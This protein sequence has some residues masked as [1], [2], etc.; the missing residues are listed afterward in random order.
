MTQARLAS[1]KFSRRYRRRSDRF[2]RSHQKLDQYQKSRRKLR[3]R[4]DLFRRLRRK[5]SRR[6]HRKLRVKFGRRS[7]RKSR[8]RYSRR[9]HPI[10]IGRDQFRKLRPIR[11]RSHIRKF[12]PRKHRGRFLKFPQNE[13]GRFLK[14][15]RKERDRYPKSR[16]TGPDRYPKSHRILQRRRV[17]VR[18]KNEGRSQPAGRS[19]LRSSA[20]LSSRDDNRITQTGCTHQHADP[21]GTLSFVSTRFTQTDARTRRHSRSDLL[22]VHVFRHARRLAYQRNALRRLSLHVGRMDMDQ[23]RVWRL[24]ERRRVLPDLSQQPRSDLL[25]SRLHARR[26]ATVAR[27]SRARVHRLLSQERRLEPL[28]RLRF[29]RRLSTNASQHRARTR[30]EAALSAHSDHDGRRDV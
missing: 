13:H 6:S 12:R 7:L 22:A 8:V 25:Q 5:F 30:A 3:R 11:I 18:I 23:S 29:L 24:R 21:L 2:R 26:S 27:D 4:S 14:S 28:Q 1:L 15:R 10:H 19:R 9:S 20:E 17:N 16:R